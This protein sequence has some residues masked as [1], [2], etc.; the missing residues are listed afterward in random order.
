MTE[1]VIVQI[2]I[3]QLHESPFNPRKR[4]TGIKEL[5]DARC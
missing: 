4:F 1:D 3:D 2:P 5:A